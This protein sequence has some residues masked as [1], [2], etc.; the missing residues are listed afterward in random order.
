MEKRYEQLPSTS[1][2]KLRVYGRD[3]RELFKNA[4][5]AMFENIAPFVPKDQAESAPLTRRSVRVSGIDHE[6]LLVEFL[7]E[8]LYL[9]HQYKE[10]YVHADIEQLTDTDLVSNIHGRA[11]GGFDGTEIKAV[12]HHGVRIT[13]VDGMLQTEILFDI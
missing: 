9:S 5:I 11:A 4:L 2:L 10:I 6:H 13:S 1:E 8:A 7:S 3:L 12:T